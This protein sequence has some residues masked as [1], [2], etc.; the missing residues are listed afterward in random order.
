MGANIAASIII[1]PFI[2]AVKGEEAQLAGGSEFKS[3]TLQTRLQLLCCQEIKFQWKSRKWRLFR[4][5]L[6]PR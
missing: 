1:C 3:L 4:L 5:R 2:L 6:S